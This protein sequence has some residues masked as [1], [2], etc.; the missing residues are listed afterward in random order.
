MLKK[1]LIITMLTLCG[2]INIQA[3]EENEKDLTP[4][5]LVCNSDETECLKEEGQEESTASILFSVFSEDDQDELKVL[6]CKNC[7]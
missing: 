4:G 7:L 2:I 1:T 3:T 6:A 5:V